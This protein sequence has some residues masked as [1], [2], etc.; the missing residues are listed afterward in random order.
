[1]TQSGDSSKL[2]MVA[3]SVNPSGAGSR[4]SSTASPSPAGAP[5][6][7]VATVKPC[8]RSA[9]APQITNDAKT[10]P[11]E[12]KKRP[13]PTPASDSS[14]GDGQPEP[15][16]AARTL[17]PAEVCPSFLADCRHCESSRLTAAPIVRRTSRRPRPRSLSRPPSSPAR[18]PPSPTWSRHFRSRLACTRWRRARLQVLRRRSAR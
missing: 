12:S 6:A 9:L 11:V 14:S 15:C 2:P 5:V 4:A 10:P 1:M 17:V 16:K 8:V 18:L 3:A 7:V 13:A